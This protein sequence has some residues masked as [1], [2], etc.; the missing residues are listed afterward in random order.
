MKIN[1]QH[2]KL[3]ITPGLFLVILLCNFLTIGCREKPVQY[4]AEEKQV[5]KDSL[6][7]IAIIKAQAD[8]ATGK[9]N[10]DIPLP[11]PY[12]LP[13]AEEYFAIDCKKEIHI[14]NNNTGFC[15]NTPQEEITAYY[16]KNDI[17]KDELARLLRK[18]FGAGIINRVMYSADSLYKK[19]PMRYGVWPNLVMYYK[20]G[21]S[22]PFN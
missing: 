13:Y 5:N 9:F 14:Q 18:D 8:Y 2:S 15:G 17:Y 3:T 11:H 7:S 19:D 21:V 10:L 22:R 20:N 6:R 1:S 4:E 12:T 16:Y